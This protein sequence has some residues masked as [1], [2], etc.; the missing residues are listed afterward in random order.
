MAVPWADPWGVAWG[1]V[2]GSGGLLLR[3]GGCNASGSA[4]VI[5]EVTGGLWTAGVGPSG[6]VTAAV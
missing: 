6:E 3:L 1:T 5:A 2:A 4:A